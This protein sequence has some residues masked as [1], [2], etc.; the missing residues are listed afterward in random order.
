M[1]LIIATEILVSLRYKLRMFG[2]PADSPA[3]VFCENYSVTKNVT[4]SQLVMN[5]I[6]MQYVITDYV[7]NRPQISLELVGSKVI[8]TKII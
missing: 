4:L 3:Y 1:G 7:R 2:V 6:K 5:N 8:I